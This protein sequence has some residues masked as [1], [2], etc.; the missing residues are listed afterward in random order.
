MAAKGTIAKENIKKE[1]INL[2]GQDKAFEVD[3]KIYINT[4]ENG[5]PIQI[6]LTMTCPKTFIESDGYAAVSSN[7]LDFEDDSSS[8]GKPAKNNVEISDEEKQNIKDLME[9]LGL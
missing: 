4:T 6:A 7:A 2:F 8:I 1:I 5:E 3:K 9:R